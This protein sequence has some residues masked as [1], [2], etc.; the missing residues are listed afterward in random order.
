MGGRSILEPLL[1]KTKLSISVRSSFQ[2]RKRKSRAKKHDRHQPPY[3]VFRAGPRNALAGSKNKK[4]WPLFK[5]KRQ[6]KKLLAE[7]GRMRFE[8]AVEGL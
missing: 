4:M 6:K 2:L 1:V 3:V 5:E 7:M 8:P